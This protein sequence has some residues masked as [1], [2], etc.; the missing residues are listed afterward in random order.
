MAFGGRSVTSLAAIVSGGLVL[1]L[2]ASTRTI[3]MKAYDDSP[4]VQVESQA[5]KYPLILTVTSAARHTH[6]GVTTTTG[7]GVLTL[8]DDPSKPPENISFQ[9][10]TGVFSR[11]GKNT[12]PA[13]VHKPFQLKIAA[14]EMGSDK[15]KEFTCKY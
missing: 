8:K 3:P 13:R 4:T 9:C 11:A 2:A 12:Y 6:K 1:T 7:T 15:V 10:D 5:N 14:R